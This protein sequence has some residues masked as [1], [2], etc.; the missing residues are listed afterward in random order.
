[1]MFVWGTVLSAVT[2]GIFYFVNPD[3][4]AGSY[5]DRADREPSGCCT[6]FPAGAKLCDKLCFTS[7]LDPGEEHLCSES[8]QQARH[9]GG[10]DNE[11]K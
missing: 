5:T 3:E 2:T 1:M 4:D 8:A 9:S 7:K 6:T 10:Q 11:C